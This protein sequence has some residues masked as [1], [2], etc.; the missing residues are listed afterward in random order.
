MSFVAVRPPTS[1]ANLSESSSVLAPL[2]L[3]TNLLVGK[4]DSIVASTDPEGTPKKEAAPDTAR[5]IAAAPQQ[6]SPSTTPSSPGLMVMSFPLVDPSRK[7]DVGPATHHGSRPVT[8]DLL[9]ACHLEEQ[10]EPSFH[11][12]PSRQ[13]TESH[14]EVPTSTPATDATPS[15]LEECAQEPVVV[16]PPLQTIELGEQ[17]T[18]ASSAANFILGGGSKAA[19]AELME[20]RRRE[21]EEDSSRAKSQGSPADVSAMPSDEIA[22]E[23]V[24]TAEAETVVT[25]LTR[26]P[27]GVDALESQ[28]TLPQVRTESVSS[29]WEEY[30]LAVSLGDWG[31]LL[32]LLSAESPHSAWP[33]VAVSAAI[34]TPHPELVEKLVEERNPR[35]LPRMVRSCTDARMV[36][37][38][39]RHLTQDAVVS[40]T[41]EETGDTC[42]HS[43][44]D[45]SSTASRA[46]VLTSLLRLGADVN[47]P[48][49]CG[50]SPVHIAAKQ[51][52]VSELRVLLRNNGDAN[53]LTKEHRTPAFLNVMGDYPRLEVLQ[54]L[55]DH[56]AN[57]GEEVPSLRLAYRGKNDGISLFLEEHCA[58][59]DPDGSDSNPSG[60]SRSLTETTFLEETADTTTTTLPDEAAEACKPEA[61]LW[62][63][64]KRHLTSALQGRVSRWWPALLVLLL[65][66][67]VVLLAGQADYW[68]RHSGAAPTAQVV[69]TPRM[70]GA[71]NRTT[72]IGLS[73]QC[74]LR[75]AVTTV[76]LQQCPL[77]KQ[78]PL[79]AIWA[80]EEQ[81][82]RDYCAVKLLE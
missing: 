70:D 21:S 38:L 32:T 52:R 41:D 67:L 37:L 33:E 73:H 27:G 19:D 72:L 48:N 56:G 28:T 6:A 5:A 11:A 59:A 26:S 25:V 66:V 36:D 24:T 8:P 65:L 16:L 29:R 76:Q 68:P 57:L 4:I 35:L 60:S 71:E 13:L 1:T 7:T 80:E 54:L 20:L 15:H 63:K 82:Q 62:H 58:Q 30:R 18:L 49:L 77:L 2:P 61:S 42:L 12:G 46:E 3:N 44:D 10:E 22:K 9:A 50:E 45:S 75:T 55:L 81:F 17:L 31:S 53:A 43:L 34:S 79:P 40:Y 74:P 69:E 23:D 51:G 78:C 47:K 64:N 14:T 39:C